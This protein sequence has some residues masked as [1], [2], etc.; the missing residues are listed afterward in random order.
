VPPLDT[1]VPLRDGAPDVQLSYR[2]AA[3]RRDFAHE[4]LERAPST[5]G[6]QGP[7]EGQR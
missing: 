6:A 1:V 3:K 4:Y 5:D 2:A 7:T